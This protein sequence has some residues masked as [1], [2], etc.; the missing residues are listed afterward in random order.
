MLNPLVA[1]AFHFQKNDKFRWF[2]RG[3]HFQ[4]I[5][6]E[7]PKV[8]PVTDTS[9]ESGGRQNGVLGELIRDLGPRTGSSHLLSP[10]NIEI[11]SCLSPLLNQVLQVGRGHQEENAQACTLARLPR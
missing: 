10:T 3:F 8:C 7:S 11:V 1:R 2:A 4:K 5:V 6:G 9:I